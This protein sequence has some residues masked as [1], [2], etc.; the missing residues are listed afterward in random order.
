MTSACIVQIVQISAAGLGCNYLLLALLARSKLSQLSIDRIV[1]IV[2]VPSEITIPTNDQCVYSLDSLDLCPQ[3]KDELILL[4]TPV[5]LKI[6]V[7]FL[8]TQIF[9]FKKHILF[10][11]FKKK[12]YLCIQICILREVSPIHDVYSHNFFRVVNALVSRSELRNFV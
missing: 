12:Q 8:I 10:G 4:L 9:L 7:K 3:G 5:S 11:Q 6:R 1:Q 2:Y